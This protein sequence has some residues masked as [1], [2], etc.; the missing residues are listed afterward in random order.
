MEAGKQVSLTP[1]RAI[2]VHP[3]L[4]WVQSSQRLGR[5]ADRSSH[6]ASRE[7]LRSIASDSRD[8]GDEF[9]PNPDLRSVKP[10]D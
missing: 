2:A 1:D 9:R 5:G 7:K 4:A 3:S 6:G 10:S 8:L